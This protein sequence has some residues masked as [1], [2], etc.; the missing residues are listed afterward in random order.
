MVHIDTAIAVDKED[1]QDILVSAISWYRYL[2]PPFSTR[3]LTLTYMKQNMPAV[4][5]LHGTDPGTLINTAGIR[6][7]EKLAIKNIKH[8]VVNLLI[9]PSLKK[10]KLNFEYECCSS[11]WLLTAA[12]RALNDWSRGIRG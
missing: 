10:L 4:I 6:T 1:P 2:D 12:I 5:L 8:P 7:L 11:H 3:G 9:K